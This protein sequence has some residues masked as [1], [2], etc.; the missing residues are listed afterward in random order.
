MGRHVFHA[1]VDVL[2]EHE[3]KGAIEE[4]IRRFGHVD[5]LVNNAGVST[6]RGPIWAETLEEY[7]R[8]VNVNVRGVW[9][10]M[11]YVL[12]H[13]IGRGYGRI[14]NNASQLAHKPAPD[15]ATY[16]ASKAAVVALTVSV[17]QEVADKGVTVNAICPGPTDTSLWRSGNKDGQKW[18]IESMPLRRVGTAAEQA[19]AYVYIASDEASY[20][21]GQSISPNGGDVMW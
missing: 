13:M 5:V 12:P 2:N 21:T 1:M 6:H 4:T 16:C 7:Q 10:G 20:L 8:L 11:K 18:K 19:W 17:A 14:I 3:V 15:R 9:F